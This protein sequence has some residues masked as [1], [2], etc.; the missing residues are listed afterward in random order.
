MGTD[1]A[2]SGAA[3]VNEGAVVLNF[4]VQCFLQFGGCFLASVKPTF[5]PNFINKLKKATL[6]SLHLPV[7]TSKMTQKITR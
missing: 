1:L 3:G 4:S 5:S 7:V 6:C 2:G